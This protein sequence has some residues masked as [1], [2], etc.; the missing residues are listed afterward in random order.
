M[1]KVILFRIEHDT[2]G[3]GPFQTNDYYGTLQEE[4]YWKSE[5]HKNLN[6]AHKAPK[7]NNPHYDEGIQTLFDDKIHYCAYKSLEDLLEYNDLVT[8]IGL[9]DYGFSIYRLEVSEAILGKSQAVF[10]KEHI[11]SR[12][13][14][15][16]LI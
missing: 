10:S 13:D 4:V 11:I 7:F 3:V 8:L 15:S 9:I 1:E 14:I 6:I 5:T 12:E 2:D 16:N